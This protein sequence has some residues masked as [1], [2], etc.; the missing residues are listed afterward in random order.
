[1]KP[2]F[3][4]IK[5]CLEQCFP[6]DLHIKHIKSRENLNVEAIPTDYD[7]F[8]SD[9]LELK[10]PNFALD[11]IEVFESF[12]DGMKL[13]AELYQKLH[14]P[15]VVLTRFPVN[16]LIKNF[17]KLQ[18][19]PQFMLFPDA[20]ASFKPLFI[21]GYDDLR[22]KLKAVKDQRFMLY[23][24]NDIRIVTKP[25]TRK[26]ERLDNWNIWMT[27]FRNLADELTS[28]GKA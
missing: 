26:G 19:S 7:L 13:I 11:S 3:E 28:R 24:K 17:G 20:K 10:A 27:D 15:V 5:F 16:N 12:C 6:D 21:D 1:V 22:I 8:I 14:C 18:D 23:N 2:D 25:F 9:I 4:D